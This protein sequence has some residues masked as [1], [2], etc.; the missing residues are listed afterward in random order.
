M[1]VHFTIISKVTQYSQMETVVVS[2]TLKLKEIHIVWDL[3]IFLRYSHA[4][5]LLHVENYNIF[6]K[7]ITVHR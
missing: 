7:S 4:Q 1:H 3:W 6:R 5:I 2:F